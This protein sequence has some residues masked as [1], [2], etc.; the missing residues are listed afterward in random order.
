MGVL[1]ASTI[2]ASGIWGALLGSVATGAGEGSYPA[3]QLGESYGTGRSSGIRHRQ[4]LPR[5]PV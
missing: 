2:T 4:A 3:R 1:M 5:T